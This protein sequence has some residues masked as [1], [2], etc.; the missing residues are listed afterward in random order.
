[1]LDAFAMLSTTLCILYVMFR[2]AQ[3]DKTIPWFERESPPER[4]PASTR[5]ETSRSGLNRL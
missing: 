3:L 4:Q 2:A 1:M 5:R